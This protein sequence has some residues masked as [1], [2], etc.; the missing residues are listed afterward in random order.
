MLARQA[1][2]TDVSSNLFG[3][4]DPKHYGSATLADIEERVTKLGE[5]LGVKV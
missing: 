3:E 1:A 2:E 5:E 4:R